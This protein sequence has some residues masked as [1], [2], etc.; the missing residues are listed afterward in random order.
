MVELHLPLGFSVEA[1]A[2]DHP[3]DLTQE[4]KTATSTFRNST[5]INS[6]DFPILAKYHFLPFPIVKP[7]LEAGP[8]FRATG[9]VSNY[10][11]K[12]G[13]TI[14]AGVEIKI[15]RLRVEPE[16]RYIRWGRTLTSP[17]GKSGH[18]PGTFQRQPGSISG[19]HCVLSASSVR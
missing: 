5:I 12:A 17:A 1:D 2:L 3:L 15:L 13:F 19:R 18:Q 9:A 16:L 4:I 14:G 8:S 7:Y 6:W 10:F 11:S